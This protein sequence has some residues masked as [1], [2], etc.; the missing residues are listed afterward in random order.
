MNREIDLYSNCGI[1]SGIQIPVPWY[2]WVT[3]WGW[4]SYIPSRAGVFGHIMTWRTMAYSICN[5]V[6]NPYAKNIGGFAGYQGLI[7]NVYWNTGLTLETTTDQRYQPLL[8]SPGWNV[9]VQGETLCPPGN[10]HI[11]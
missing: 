2:G 5:V 11:L 8:T 7:G 9:Q 10:C 4:V 6:Q 3:G 1:W